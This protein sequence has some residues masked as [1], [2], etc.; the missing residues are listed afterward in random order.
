M[1]GEES[2]CPRRGTGALLGLGDEELAALAAAGDRQAFEVLFTRFRLLVYRVCMRVCGDPAATEDLV[3]D[4]F[5]KVWRALRSGAHPTAFQPWICRIAR[6]TALDERARAARRTTAELPPTLESP[7]DTAGIATVSL[8]LRALIE[9]IRAL[10]A[11]QRQALV[12][13]ALQGL[14]FAEIGSLLGIDPNAAKRAAE[15][16]RKNLELMAAGR[17]RRCEELCALLTAPRRGRL[18]AWVHAHARACPDCAQ[19]LRKHIR[20]HAA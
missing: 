7:L 11:R 15:A 18:P 12:L 13:R 9:D 2:P 4:T 16:G 19:L 20:R 1:F 5:L 10:P 8:Q 14:T 6:N 3:Q 17:E